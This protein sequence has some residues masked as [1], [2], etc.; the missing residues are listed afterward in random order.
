MAIS[1]LVAP[2]VSPQPKWLIFVKGAIILLPAVILALAAYALSLYGDI[3]Y[4]YSAGASGYLLFV[5]RPTFTFPLQTSPDSIL[6]NSYTDYL[7]L[8][9]LWHCYLLGA[10]SRPVLLPHCDAG[11]LHPD[12]RLLALRLG[13]VSILGGVFSGFL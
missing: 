12:L 5:V 9:R 13:F 4:Y 8:D 1:G 3:A 10:Q 6:T 2:G 7:H 11:C